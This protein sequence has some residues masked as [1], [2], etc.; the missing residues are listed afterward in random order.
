MT[1]LGIVRDTL[2][3]SRTDISIVRPPLYPSIIKNAMAH[4]K[5]SS[6]GVIIPKLP[7]DM[8][9]TV[10]ESSSLK[11]WMSQRYRRDT[12]IKAD[13]MKQFEDD[14]SVLD[15]DDTRSLPVSTLIVNNSDELCV[16]F[17]V[18]DDDELSIKEERIVVAALIKRSRSKKLNKIDIDAVFS[19]VHPTIKIADINPCLLGCQEYAELK[20]DPEGYIE[21]KFYERPYEADI[22]YLPKSV[23]FKDITFGALRVAITKEAESISLPRRFRH[24]KPRRDDDISRLIIVR[25]NALLDDFIGR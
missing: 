25:D 3:K 15:L 24:K 4:I 19:D 18:N 8:S 12:L 1:E 11:D 23:L 5:E 13:R 14:L 2:I 21:D 16:E 9:L 7:P 17:E 22:N 10:L 20:N 6:G